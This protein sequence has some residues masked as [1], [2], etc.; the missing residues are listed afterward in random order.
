MLQY[1]STLCDKVPKNFKIEFC[2]QQTWA[3]FVQFMVKSALHSLLELTQ[4]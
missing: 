4:S 1:Y 2:E 3:K